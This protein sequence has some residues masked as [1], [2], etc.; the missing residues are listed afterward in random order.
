MYFSCEKCCNANYLEYYQNV[1]SLWLNF[2]DPSNS[3]DQARIRELEQELEK[4]KRRLRFE[5]FRNSDKKIRYY[6]GLPN[7]GTFLWLLSMFSNFSFNY[8]GGRQVSILSREDQLFLFLMKL[9]LNIGHEMLSDWFRV[10]RGTITSVFHTWLDALH[11]VV[12]LGFM[13]VVPSREANAGSMPECFKSYPNCRMV[14]D[15]TEVTVDIPGKMEMH[16]VV[17]S[18]YKHRTTLKGLVGVAPNGTVT[19]ASKLYPGSTSDKAIVKD[20][21]VLD[22]FVPGDCILADKGFLIADLLPPGVTVNIPPFL[23]TPQF[24]LQQIEKTESIAKARIHVER[25][26]ER[27]K[28]FKILNHIKHMSVAD[29]SK[30]FQVCCALTNFKTYLIRKV[31]HAMSV[32]RNDVMYEESDVDD[33]DMLYFNES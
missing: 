28:C 7:A 24:T 11:R 10:S 22:C 2:R 5:H 30:I 8:Y 18:H 23:T 15:C 13:K 26:N 17:Y 4:E 21:G 29:A 31:A 6:T 14:L 16:N 20:C 27:I 32:P 1:V 3:R 25:A 19:F 12:F 33:D 9:N